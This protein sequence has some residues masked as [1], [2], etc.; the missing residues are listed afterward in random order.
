MVSIGSRS[1]IR[2]RLQD[3]V[4]VRLPSQEIESLQSN[5]FIPSKSLTIRNAALVHGFQ[6]SEVMLAIVRHIL[7]TT[8]NHSQVY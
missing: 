8:E 7:E 4:E 5:R 1:S 6:A 2:G 3:S